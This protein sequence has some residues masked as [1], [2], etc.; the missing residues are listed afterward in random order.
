MEA[1]PGDLDH[2]GNDDSQ[3]TDTDKA[4]GERRWQLAARRRRQ[5]YSQQQLAEAVGVSPVTIRRWEKGGSDVGSR[6]P[7]AR[8]L[9]VSMDRLE[10][11]LNN[12]DD[13]E[14]DTPEK[15]RPLVP[16]GLSVYLSMEHSA[17]LI[18]AYQ[19]HFIHG[20][21]QTEDYARALVEASDYAGQGEAQID[22]L[23]GFRTNRRQEALTRDDD[24]LQLDLVLCET[25]LYQRSGGKAAMREQLEH[26]ARMTKR[27]N[28]TIR[29]LA[30]ASG[31]HTAGY[32]PFAILTLPWE[33]VTVGYVNSYVGGASYVESQ[34]E[35]DFLTD[36]YDRI[37]TQSLSPKD[38]VS[39]IRRVAAEE[40]S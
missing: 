27:P 37:R 8:A 32:G 3:S 7:L 20:L 4:T 39:L 2:D 36:L 23:V 15:V 19:P 35:M 6:R 9:D 25:A 13:E 30:F 11:I 12:E 28:V 34:H 29:I 14:D 33:E 24:P 38:S 5:G 16:E 21:L 10:R 1:G 40:Y 22:R 26:V 18:Q 31:P 17:S